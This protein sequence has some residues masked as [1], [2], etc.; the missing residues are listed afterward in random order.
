MAAP[1]P[2]LTILSYHRVL[3]KADP[4]LPEH[5]TQAQFAAQLRA[6]KRFLRFVPL[7][8]GWEMVRN[9]TTREHLAT[10]TFDDGY[11]DNLDV[12]LPV[13]ESL[14]IPATLFIATAYTGRDP[15]FVGRITECIART[16]QLT[17]SGADLGLPDLDLSNLQQR[18]QSADNIL[19]F[20]KYRP[21]E[22]RDRL[23][24]EIQRRLE[25]SETPRLMLNESEVRQAYQRGMRIAAH[26]HSHAI[27]TTVSAEENLYHLAENLRVI[28]SI[29]GVRPFEFAYPN[30]RPGLDFTESHRASI[31]AGGIKIAVTS[32]RGI[33][34]PLSDPLLLPRY[35]P[36]GRNPLTFMARLLLGIRQATRRVGT[37]SDGAPV[38]A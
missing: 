25:V 30:G 37:P 27:M 15:F 21:P 16:T 3:A 31:A 8:Q 17:L 7:A 4:F 6:A 5:P 38:D 20:I 29:T 26:T 13:L 22:E 28:E 35:G 9:R 34:T 32:E 11:R 1:G 18:R 24:V 19:E 14:E 10:V 33:C 36:W 2:S 23:A 12:A